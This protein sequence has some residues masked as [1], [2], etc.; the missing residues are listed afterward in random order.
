MCGSPDEVIDESIE[1]SVK[2]LQREDCGH[3]AVV[4]ETAQPPVALRM[5]RRDAARPAAQ[6]L[7]PAHAVQSP[8]LRVR[9]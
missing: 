8:R 1:A 2:H 3:S 7:K 5:R 9:G 4:Q 6:M